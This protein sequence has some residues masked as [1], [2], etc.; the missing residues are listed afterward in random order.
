MKGNLLCLP[1][2][3]HTCGG[4]GR[5][6]GGFLTPIP[7]FMSPAP[8][9]KLR[10]V[11]IPPAGFLG[12]VPLPFLRGDPDPCQSRTMAFY[13]GQHTR[14]AGGGRRPRRPFL[15]FSIVKGLILG[16]G[17]DI[18]LGQ[19]G[20]K[21]FQF[22]FTWHTQWQPFEEVATSPEP[23]TIAHIMKYLSCVCL[24]VAASLAALAAGPSDDAKAFK[25]VGCPSRPSWPD[26]PCPRL[27]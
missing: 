7:S 27:S 24:A 9:P 2:P 21:P 15:F 22:M 3:P 6:K 16:A 13:S 4:E 18:L 11:G 10:C 5:E 1:P 8:P 14:P 26:S 25:E 20:Q 23:G 19:G 12:S 17:G